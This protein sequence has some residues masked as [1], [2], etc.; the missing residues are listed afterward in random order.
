MT[1]DPSAPIHHLTFDAEVSNDVEGL[2]VLLDHPSPVVR[3]GALYGLAKQ[4]P[5]PYLLA[6][7]ERQTTPHFEPSSGVRAVAQEIMSAWAVAGT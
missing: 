3:E 1:L 5:S 2:L 7:V 4:A 6:A